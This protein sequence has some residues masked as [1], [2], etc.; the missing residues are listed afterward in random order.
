MSDPVAAAAASRDEDA[1]EEVDDAASRRKLFY[2]KFTGVTT[3]E[4]PDELKNMDERKRVR[5]LQPCFSL[6]SILLTLLCGYV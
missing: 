4:K 1:W 3:F 6:C 2:N 5:R